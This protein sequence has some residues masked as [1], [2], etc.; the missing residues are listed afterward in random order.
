MW[1]MPYCLSSTASDQRIA[2]Y[3]ASLWRSTEV[4][5]AGSAYQALTLRRTRRSHS[6]PRHSMNLRHRSTQRALNSGEVQERQEQ[7][8]ACTFRCKRKRAGFTQEGTR[9]WVQTRLRLVGNPCHGCHQGEF[10]RPVVQYSGVAGLGSRGSHP[11]QLVEL[12]SPSS[13]ITTTG[14]APA[15]PPRAGSD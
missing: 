14:F 5:A 8:K 15:N 2:L 3:L 6:A 10:A 9:L 4:L 11:Q 7:K 1:R 12:D 13:D